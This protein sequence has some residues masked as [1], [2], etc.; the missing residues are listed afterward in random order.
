M[1]FGVRLSHQPRSPV[2]ITFTSHIGQVVLAQQHAERI[3]LAR[4]AECAFTDSSDCSDA[5][6]CR[7]ENE[8]ET[9]SCVPLAELP[10]EPPQE[11]AVL[12]CAPSD[13]DSCVV[14]TELTLELSDWDSSGL[15]L[16]HIRIAGELSCP[17]WRAFLRDI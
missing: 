4:R 17:R 14:E 13:P 12:V 6:H 7:W 10:V 1:A 11:L 15:L 9:H 5:E 8:T 16:K 3:S 2:T